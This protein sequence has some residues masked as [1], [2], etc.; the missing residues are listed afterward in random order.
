MT[1]CPFDGTI[2]LVPRYMR[3]RHHANAAQAAKITSAEPPAPP[4]AAV[5]APL[6]SVDAATFELR[7]RVL[8]A[9]TANDNE[10]SVQGPW[11]IKAALVASIALGLWMLVGHFASASEI[12]H[13]PM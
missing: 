1:P 2:G 3:M 10:A 7:A 5:E 9:A 4:P 8:A 6:R 11:R 13:L 12:V